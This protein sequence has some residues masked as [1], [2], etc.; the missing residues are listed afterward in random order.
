MIITPEKIPALPK[1]AMARPRMKAIE[2]GAAPQM[3]EPI[4]NNATA[5]RNT[6]VGANMISLVLCRT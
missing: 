1:P 2:F 3:T 5:I 4:S 6:L